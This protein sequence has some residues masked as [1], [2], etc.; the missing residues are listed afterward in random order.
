M[1]VE[2]TR[3]FTFYTPPFRIH[4]HRLSFRRGWS[5][6]P[7]P[8][9]V[10]LFAAGQSLPRKYLSCP[11]STF[12]DSIWPRLALSVLLLGVHLRL[13][14]CLAITTKPLDLHRL[15]RRLVTHGH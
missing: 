8:S 6:I 2:K 14:R 15:A 3:P 7:S 9:L 13:W 12:D 11:H 4:G 10:P 5:S 1:T